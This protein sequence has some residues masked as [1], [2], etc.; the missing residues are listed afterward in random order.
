MDLQFATLRHHLRRT[1]RPTRHDVQHPHNTHLAEH[2]GPI[3]LGYQ[4]RH[5]PATESVTVAQL[6]ARHTATAGGTS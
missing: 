6:I 5:R 1:D 4:G 2:T 3:P